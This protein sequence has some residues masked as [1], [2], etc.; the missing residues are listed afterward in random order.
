[1]SLVENKGAGVIPGFIF[2][3]MIKQPTIDECSK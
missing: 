1:M 2:I 3:S